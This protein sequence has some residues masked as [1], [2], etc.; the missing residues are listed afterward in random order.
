MGG[1]GTWALAAAHP[2]KFAAIAPICGGGEIEDAPKLA[3]MPIWVFHGAKDATVPLQ[4]SKDMVEALKAAGGKP[5]FTIYPDAGHDSWTV[6][7][8][9]PEFYQWLLAQNRARR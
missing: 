7:Y 1:Y 4:A 2:E 9:N 8:E 3:N 5:K 6:T